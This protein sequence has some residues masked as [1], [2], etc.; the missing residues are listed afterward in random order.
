MMRFTLA[1]VALCGASTFAGP[2]AAMPMSGIARL[3]PPANLQ[4]IADDCGRYR[5]WW[6]PS[7]YDTPPHLRPRVFYGYAPHRHGDWFWYLYGHDRSGLR[8]DWTRW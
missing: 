6:W 5:C 8:K 7:Y 2:C 1:A 4:T 3:E